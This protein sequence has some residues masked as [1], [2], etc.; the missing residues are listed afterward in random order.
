M[1]PRC[2]LLTSLI[3]AGAAVTVRGWQINSRHLHLRQAA[4]AGPCPAYQH[5]AGHWSS[6]HPDCVSSN[7]DLDILCDSF[8]LIHIIY[9][10]YLVRPQVTSL[11]PHSVWRVAMIGEYLQSPH[12]G[13]SRQNTHIRN[14]EHEQWM[15][16]IVQTVSSMS[17]TQ[18][19]SP[20]VVITAISLFSTPHI[21]HYHLF[22][23]FHF[24]FNQNSSK[25]QWN[26]AISN[27]LERKTMKTE[28]CWFGWQPRVM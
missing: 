8:R 14:H 26:D 13:Q 12:P 2:V 18:Q 6:I 19:S 4:S 1:C 15:Q 10:R 28:P 11:F 25:S 7:H 23:A 20:L 16:W 9:S 22:R 24:H 5:Q 27:K 21:R 3:P 17:I